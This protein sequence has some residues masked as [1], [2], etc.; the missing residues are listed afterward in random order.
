[1]D[2]VVVA[3]HYKE[4]YAPYLIGISLDSSEVGF[5]PRNYKDVF[6]RARAA[7][8]IPVAHEVRKAL[9]NMFAMP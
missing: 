1:M 4:R 7:R 8:C 2:T 9:P 5:P 3:E 6:D